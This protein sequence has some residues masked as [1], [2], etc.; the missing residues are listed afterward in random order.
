ML[1]F[2]AIVIVTAGTTWSVYTIVTA[3]AASYG[4]SA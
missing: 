2:L 3:M 4:F 1:F